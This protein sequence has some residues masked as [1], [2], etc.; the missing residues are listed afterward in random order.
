MGRCG[1]RGAHFV[2]DDGESGAG[3]LPGGFGAGESC[4]DDVDRGV[5]VLL[6]L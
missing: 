2:E 1:R 3:D 5:H 4:A 6:I